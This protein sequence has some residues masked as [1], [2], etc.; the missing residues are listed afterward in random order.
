MKKINQYLPYAGALPFVFCALFFIK[1]IHILPLLGYTDRILSSYGLII[2]SF[3]A[4]SHWGQHL[5]LSG[6]WGICLPV[7]SN[8]NAV[9][10][11]VSFVIFSFKILFF[12]LAISFLALL[13]IDQK[14]CQG[15]VISCEYFRTRFLVTLIV[16]SSLIISGYYA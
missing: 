16:I 12:I 11:W 6:K 15:G 3:M 14:L 4:G 2:S 9:L 8:I 1:D 13:L 5:N 10:L 7:F